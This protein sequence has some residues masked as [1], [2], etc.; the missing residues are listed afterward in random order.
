MWLARSAPRT[1]TRGHST[2]PCPQAW[3]QRD[4]SAGGSGSPGPC[5]RRSSLF[6][7]PVEGLV[8]AGAVDHVRRGGADA[9]DRLADRAGGVRPRTGTSPQRSRATLVEQR[10]LE[11]YAAPDD[12]RSSPAG[13]RCGCTEPATSTGSHLDGLTHLP[14]PIAANGERV[15]ARPRVLMRRFTVPPDEVVLVHGIRCASV[16]R[17]LYDELPTARGVRERRSTIDMACAARLTSIV[18]CG[19]YCAERR[20]YRDVRC[21]H[22]R[23]TWPTSAAG[24]PQESGSG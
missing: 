23:S 21:V 16:E 7:P 17:S 18:G 14:V 10:I 3:T 5:R 19:A 9:A 15:R 8:L 13:H 2:E 20:W 24:R 4:S 6:A 22:G 12:E 1:A 11:L